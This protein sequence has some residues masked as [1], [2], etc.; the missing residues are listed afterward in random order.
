M[1][2]ISEHTA[3]FGCWRLVS[4]NIF[5]IIPNARFTNY[6]HC[7]RMRNWNRDWVHVIEISALESR[8]FPGD[9]GYRASSLGEFLGLL[10][11][12]RDRV[13]FQRTFSFG[14][15]QVRRMFLPTY[16][17]HIFH[18]QYVW[19]V[20]VKR[21]WQAWKYSKLNVWWN[22]TLSRFPVG[23]PRIFPMK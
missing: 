3:A 10:T 5:W 22:V 12:D 21:I 15:F 20:F 11:G 17:P 14:Y 4:W 16:G 7:Y 13:A 1:Q 9:R 2:C 6:A 18:V 23:N 19:R 8:F